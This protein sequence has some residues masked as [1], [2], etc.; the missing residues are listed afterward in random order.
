MAS[1]SPLVQSTWAR[2]TPAPAPAWR[3]GLQ[4]GRVSS[5]PEPE[6]VA[7]SRGA[8]I[9]VTCVNSTPSTSGSSLDSKRP[10]RVRRFLEPA[11]QPKQGGDR[12]LESSPRV[13][14][15]RVSVREAAIE[16]PSL[17]AAAAAL[18]VAYREPSFGLDD[19]LALS[20]ELEVVGPPPDWSLSLENNAQSPVILARG[21]GGVA[22]D[23]VRQ[24]LDDVFEMSGDLDILGPSPDDTSSFAVIDQGAGAGRGLQ[25]PQIAE[26][27]VSAVGDFAEDVFDSDLALERALDLES[28]VVET[29]TG[30]REASG[31]SSS[32]ESMEVNGSRINT[33][34]ELSRKEESALGGSE[35][36][37]GLSGEG[38]CTLT[39]NS[40]RN[41]ATAPVLRKLASKAVSL[42]APKTIKA[43]VKRGDKKVVRRR[44]GGA[45]SSVN[46]PPIRIPRAA[47][48]SADGLIDASAL[49]AIYEEGVTNIGSRAGGASRR[50]ADGMSFVNE[51]NL[52][53]AEEEKKLA[54]VIQ[55][56]KALTTLK[57]GLEASTGVPA[58]EEQWAKAAGVSV[59]ALGRQIAAGKEARQ[60]LVECNLRLVMFAANSMKHYPNALPTEDLFLAGIQ[61]LLIAA[62]RFDPALG[63]RFSTYALPAVRSYLHRAI[64]RSGVLI[65]APVKRTTGLVNLDKVRRELSAKLG[66][67]PTLDEI[68]KYKN[69]GVDLIKDVLKWHR[70]MDVT[71][72]DFSDGWEEF[73]NGALSGALSETPDGFLAMDEE[74]LKSDLEQCISTLPTKEGEVLRRRYGLAGHQP[75]TLRQIGDALGL[76]YEMVRRYEARALV[77]MRKAQRMERLSQ[78]RPMLGTAAGV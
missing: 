68:A 39:S 57:E 40:L 59:N 25:W 55:R 63:N 7:V 6:A 30:A 4:S 76:S 24:G 48:V 11:L 74:Y 43:R 20:D 46:P 49:K 67:L 44:L 8:R 52:L 60:R 65:C 22:L 15:T 69:V 77:L 75:A 17:E 19:V 12:H 26:T 58:S 27:V 16:P 2:L 5:S 56:S 31:A 53:T 14:R 78:Y 70:G 37:G 10:H 21:R 28:R 71:F 62:D 42:V 45:E 50:G 54:L 61:G 72:N 18:E 33:G 32:L 35:N 9:G 36:A 41:L 64:Q 34:V 51:W 66:R 1:A 38:L 29:E 47:A 13:V 3:D 73:A 23:S